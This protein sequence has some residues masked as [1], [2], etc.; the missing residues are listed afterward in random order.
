[1]TSVQEYI[2]L[3]MFFHL[4]ITHEFDFRKQLDVLCSCVGTFVYIVSVRSFDILI[5]NN[6]NGKLTFWLLRLQNC[7]IS[8]WSPS[9]DS[10]F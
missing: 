6:N 5:V 3:C 8:L 7:I 9:S 2:D 4:L 10:G 1:M